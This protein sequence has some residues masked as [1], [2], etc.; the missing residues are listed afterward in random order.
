MDLPVE[1]LARRY[2][3][4]ASLR[5]LADRFGIST[6]TV[7]ARLTAAGVETRRCGAPRRNVDLGGLVYETHLAG[8]VRCAAR[9]LGIDRETARRRLEELHQ[10]G[11]PATTVSF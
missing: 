7:R 8:S 3:N 10:H 6:G 2:E 5:E 9:R 11:P 1:E 4:G